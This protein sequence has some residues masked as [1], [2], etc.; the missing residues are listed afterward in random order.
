MKAIGRKT[1]ILVNVEA[2]TARAISDVPLSAASF[3]PSPSPLNR[4]MF[5]K[6]TTEFVTRIPTAVDKPM[7]VMMLSENPETWRRRKVET[8]ENG[9]ARATMMVDRISWRKKNKTNPVNRIPRMMLPRVSSTE[10]PGG[11]TGGGKLSGAGEEGLE[12]PIPPP[13]AKELQRLAGK[14]ASLLNKAE[15]IRAGYKVSD[16][17]HFKLLKAMS[18]MDRVYNDLR[19]YRYQNVLRARHAVLKAL[20][21]IGGTKTGEIDVLIDSSVNMPKYIRDNIADAM[22]GNMP[23][24]YREVLE[25]YY[26]RIGEVGAAP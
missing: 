10:P 14:Q 23:E 13:L 11:A 20:G 6:T 18:L 19:N 25:Q 1:T 15:R 9:M 8:I 12:G 4:K 3:R 2:M 7:R 22:K 21:E 16:L 26:R 5:S 17:S 24:E